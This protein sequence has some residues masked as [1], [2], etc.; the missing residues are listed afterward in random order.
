M[1][2]KKYTL[3]FPAELKQVSSKK[4]RSL[5]IEYRIIMDTADPSV[6]TLGTLAPD[7]LFNVTVEQQA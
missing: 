4:L 6:M 7:Q 2:G 5:D 3:T 1:A